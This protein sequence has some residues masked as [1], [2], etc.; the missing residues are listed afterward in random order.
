METS[1]FILISAATALILVG[2]LGYIIWR[3]EKMRQFLREEFIRKEEQ[4]SYL[5]RTAEEARTE[6]EQ[7]R[8][9][10]ETQRETL[11]QA[12]QRE[13][14]ALQQLTHL[15]KKQQEWEQLKQHFEQAAKASVLSAGQELSS[16][17]LADHKREATEIRTQFAEQ[18]AQQTQKF[19]TQFQALTES[20]S[21]IRQISTESQKKAEIMWRA[22]STPQAAGQLTEVAL[23]NLLRH[24]GLREGVDFRLQP[25]V[26]EGEGIGLRP[27]CVIYLPQDRLLI[28][29]CKASKH[30]LELESAEGEQERRAA[31]D[32]FR[33]AMHR[34]LEMLSR[35]QYSHAVADEYRQR[36]GRKPH[37]Q[38]LNVM[39]IASDAAVEKLDLLDASFRDKIQKAGIIPVGPSGLQGLCSIAS[40]QIA[41]AQK[42]ENQEQ[43]LHEI[44]RLLAGF[45]TA[46]GH[47]QKLGKAIASTAHAFSDFTGSY[48]RS[49]APKLRQIALMGIKP[50][51]KATLPDRLPLYEVKTAEDWLTLEAEDAQETENAKKALVG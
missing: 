38:I 18:Q 24:L 46:F 8:A 47:L 31:E 4:I 35:K 36:T 42:A 12:E 9:Q 29:D 39:Y 1:L 32:R 43:I 48:N 44:E 2:W 28:I 40:M 3:G 19:T 10:L 14:L 21:A 7:M 5:A 15:E 27:D 16:K 13:Q 25:S 41:E 11:Q 45:A 20:V 37:H 50:E 34:H 6:A 33:A 51:G 22:L 26:T 30:Q 49:V 23:E 17:L